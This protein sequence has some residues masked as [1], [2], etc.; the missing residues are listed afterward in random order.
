MLARP[1]CCQVGGWGVRCVVVMVWRKGGRVVE[2][3]G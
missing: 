1:F 2:G 3:L